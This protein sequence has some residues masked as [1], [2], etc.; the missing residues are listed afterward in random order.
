[1]NLDP[2]EEKLLR[3]VALQNAR[4]VLLARE[5]AERALR[6][7]EERL[8]VTLASIG[9]GVVVCDV[10]GHVTYLNPVAEA[11]TGWKQVDAQGEPL[12]KVFRIVNERTREVVDNPCERALR[13]G[14]VVGLANH[15]VLIAR[16]ET[17]RTIEDSAA[18]IRD[19]EGNVSGVVLIFRDVGERRVGEMLVQL[20]NDMLKLLVSGTPLPQVLDALAHAMEKQSKHQLFAAIH[21]LDDSATR[22]GLA[23]APSLPESYCKAT[24]GMS[25][26]SR[27]WPCC[28]AVLTRG[29]VTVK[30][31]DGD[32]Q[33]KAFAEVA[34]PLGIRAGW[35]T[36]IVSSRGKIVGTFENYY[37]Q[38]HGPS[39]QDMSVVD[40]LTRTV[41]LAIEQA[42]AEETRARLVA[43]VES[44][45]DAII[46]KDLNG[47]ITSWNLGAQRLFGYEANEVIGRSVTILLPADRLN[48]E[49]SIIDRIRRGQRIEHYETVRCRKDGTLLDISLS[50]SPI[51]N[52]EGKVVG[53]SKIARDITERR[54]AESE[55]ERLL[56]SEQEARREADVANRMKDEFLAT[57]SHELRTPLNAIMG[58][59]HILTR[60]RLDEES[61]AR[62]L[63]TIARNAS[64]Q[65]QLI[66]DL[67][68]VSR[69][70]SGRF[71][72]ESG[73]VD[74]IT[75]IE[76]ATD[77]VRPAADA[78]G[79]ELRLMLEPNAGLMSGDNA[80]L[81]QIVWNLL[82]NAVKFTPKE[83]R[84]TVRLTRED[85]NVL[86]TVSDTGEGI[87]AEFL[88]YIFDRFRQAE[89]TS[90]RHHGGLGL[91]LAI[92][93]HLV[94]AH[95]GTIRASSE[96]L[97]KGATFEVA[98]P[99][100]AVTRDPG[101]VRRAY[102]NEEAGD[103]AL[104]T[105][106]AG[107]R[108][109]VIDDEP[110]ARELLTL[111]LTQSGAEVRATATVNAALEMLGHWKPDVL[112][113][114]IGMPGE[115]GYDLIRTVRAL[116]SE[117]GGTI[118][119][120]ALTGFA[121]QEDAERA[122]LAGYQAHMPKPVSPA[123]LIDRVASLV[124]ATRPT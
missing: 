54:R 23:V 16:D 82:S 28:H 47:I 94:E 74:L 64:A 95:G 36:P 123:D 52:E 9:D 20:Q 114:D 29:L 105:I 33:W 41:A 30:D 6:E 101:S 110:D 92:V 106:L 108:V 1:M 59:T 68:D 61:Y 124:A 69:I 7:S 99:L 78:R 87:S 66:S 113:S 39:A 80:R 91:G 4:A 22:F 51:I 88:P 81:Q 100:I 121:S 5:R 32:P 120:L 116:E 86:I 67:L 27:A 65:N 85:S 111:T 8:R 19:A 96:G 15:T 63:E 26:N 56:K 38:P 45:D 3:S 62:G 112:V 49:P 11:L 77:T 53:A 44:S 102:A 79:V 17:E 58:W 46:S 43:I 34:R 70:I 115:D 73:V 37:D 10:R 84:V 76:A 93:R 35:S 89:S 109:L 21:L 71:R 31:V 103:D 117:R 50:V 48:E 72:F 122:H 118:P 55:R 75:V 25:V 12:E 98:F 42:K 24:V 60:G 40:V 57:V 119:A 13:E 107:L 97:G 90:K 2:S 14:I 18:P 83:G 104:S